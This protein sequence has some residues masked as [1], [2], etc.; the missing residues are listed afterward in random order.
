MNK[1]DKLIELLEEANNTTDTA[2]E[3]LSTIVAFI[4][5][6]YEEKEI[7]YGVIYLDSES[8]AFLSSNYNQNEN[9]VLKIEDQSLLSKLIFPNLNLFNFESTD[10]TE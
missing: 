3:E 6:Y 1:D 7:N 4:K 5:I 10:S 2:E 9:A 8:T